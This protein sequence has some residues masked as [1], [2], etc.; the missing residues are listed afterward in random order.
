M[1]GIISWIFVGR[2]RID[3]SSWIQHEHDQI[4]RY[5]RRVNHSFIFHTTN[6]RKIYHE[7][8]DIK[9]CYL[10]I[11]WYSNQSR[12]FDRA[13]KTINTFI[14]CCYRNNSRYYVLDRNLCNFFNILTL[15]WFWLYFNCSSMFS[16]NNY[17]FSSSDLSGLSIQS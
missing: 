1:Y 14:Y 11:G 3:L 6:N 17:L 10:V 5:N 12:S 4:T 9:D 16:N 13:N 15:F 7:T 8:Q 2:N